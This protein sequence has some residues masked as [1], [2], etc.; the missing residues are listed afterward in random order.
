[1]PQSPHRQPASP[2][3]ST[4]PQPETLPLENIGLAVAL[5]AQRIPE[6]VAVA[7]PDP[8]AS[9]GFRT[10][11]FADLD[12]YSSQVALAVRAAGVQPGT[13]LSLMVPPGIDF[14]A[15]V[16]GLLKAETQL[17][18]I[19]PGMGRRNLL[20]CL[21]AAEPEGIVGIR[22]AHLVRRFFHRRLPRCRH[23]FVVGPSAFS[24]ADK[25]EACRQLAPA[26]FV[27][28]RNDREAPAAII[29]TSGSTGVPK[30][31]LYR[32]RN[33]IE[34]AEQIQSWFGIQ[35]GGV[36]VSGFPLFA[37]F[38]AAMGTTTVFPKMDA[39]RPAAVD[40]QN[41]LAA[42]GR[43]QANQ[44]FGS[45]A[46]WNT[47]A[48]NFQTN[49]QRLPTLR[50]VLTAGAPVPAHV[51]R[52]VREVIAPDGEVFTPYGAT[53][54]LP[55]ACIESR[56]VLGETAAQTALGRGICV[57]R[58]FPRIEWRLIPIS[59]AP[60][61]SLSQTE[62]IPPGQIGELIVSGPVVTDRYVTRTEANAFHKIADGSRFWHRM[63]DV[64][65][66][67]EQDR[68]WFCGRKSHRVQT[69]SGT[70]FTI[71]CEAILNNHPAIYR[72]ALAG[73]GQPGSQIPVLIAEPWPGKWPA[74]KAQRSQLLKELRELAAESELTR[75]IEHFFLLRALPVDTRHNSKIFREQLAVWAA[76]QL[77]LPHP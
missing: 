47:V 36:D 16:F 59:D 26:A 15:C 35:P 17:I 32:H 12:Q 70:L 76:R 67:D 34:Q 30:G 54:A 10:I 31:V 18:L 49:G 11:S 74:N 77:A 51:L 1:M 38:N 48:S 22:L 66:F 4:A 46:L 37:L 7:E 21:A 56:E 72:S 40:P 20:E 58:K 63:G 27:P 8:R 68:F 75:G 13:R 62:P 53:E 45:P 29:F 24:G 41:I 28:P 23:N 9:G 60:L 5:A 39:T 64:G 61:N 50:R 69:A 3:L 73:V 19:D 14:V 71:P 52:R 55:V 6:Q 2:D 65:Y 43:F 57:G 25:L 42:V 33:F 44:S